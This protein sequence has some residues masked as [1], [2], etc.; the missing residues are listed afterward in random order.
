M[1]E[2]IS[3]PV[4]FGISSRAMMRNSCEEDLVALRCVKIKKSMKSMCFIVDP[5]AG[6]ETA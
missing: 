1:D 6:V 4:V 5:V 3:M 2:P